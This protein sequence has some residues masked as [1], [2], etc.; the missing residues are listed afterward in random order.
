VTSFGQRQEKYG[1][2]DSKQIYQTSKR[3]RSHAEGKGQNGK[4]AEQ[5]V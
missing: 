4:A 2:T 3:T 1:E 5:E